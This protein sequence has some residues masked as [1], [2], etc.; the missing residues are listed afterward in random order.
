MPR[1]LCA[2]A[3]A[4]FSF[5]RSARPSASVARRF[6]RAVRGET[7]VREDPGLLPERRARL[8]GRGVVALGVRPVTAPVMHLRELVLDARAPG[9]RRLGRGGLV[10]LDRTPVVTVQGVEVAD[11]SGR[12]HL[13]RR[14]VAHGAGFDRVAKGAGLRHRRDPELLIEQAHRRAV[15]AQ[16]GRPVARAR[17]EAHEISV[18]GLVQRVDRE[19]A[20]RVV[21]GRSEIALALGARREAGERIAILRAERVALGGLPVVE[22]RAVAEGEALEEVAAIQ[23]DR[24]V[25]ASL[26]YR[27]AELGHIDGEVPAVQIDR[28]TVALEPAIAECRAE[29]RERPAERAA[30]LL[31]V[32]IRPEQ[33]REGRPSLW[34]G[35]YRK[36]GEERRRLPGVGLDRGAA[37]LDAR[38]TEQANTQPAHRGSSRNVWRTPPCANFIG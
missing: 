16:R 25:E 18:R 31:V 28:V 30:G 9:R 34:L 8:P 12:R 38:R 6:A 7:P 23:T 20:L 37:D 27:A 5:E 15:L 3:R 14:L 24:V 10:A 2:W 1:M 22:L 36:I 19:P 33:C 13:A 35:R 32:G 17:V 11:R 29:H 4:R 26:T 21:D